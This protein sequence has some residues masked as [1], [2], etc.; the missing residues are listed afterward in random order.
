MCCL[1][2]WS[3]K[4]LAPFPI[5]VRKME[6][7]SKLKKFDG[8]QGWMLL[9]SKTTSRPTNNWL[10]KSIHTTSRQSGF[11]GWDQMGPGYLIPKVAPGE[12]TQALQILLI[13]A[14][15]EPNPG[16][17]DEP[18]A[19]SIC[20]SNKWNTAGVWCGRGGWVHVKCTNLTSDRQWSPSFDC[21]RCFW[22][23]KVESLFQEPL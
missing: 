16:P 19:C 15:I 9:R 20:S 18:I 11:L 13:R 14:G 5:Y 17:L 8:F 22:C 2:G 3:R 6:A 12:H 21:H 1:R 7:V 4:R 23:I 10:P